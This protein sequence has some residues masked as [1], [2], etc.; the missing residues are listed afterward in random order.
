VGAGRLRTVD[1]PRAGGTGAG[2]INNRGQ[3]LGFA[4]NPEDP[5]SPPPTDTAPMGRKA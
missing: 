5:A 2:G 1:G 4:V 3:I